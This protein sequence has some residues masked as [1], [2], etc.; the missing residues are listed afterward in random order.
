MTAMREREWL[1]WADDG[2]PAGEPPEPGLPRM[3]TEELRDF[4]VG[5]LN[6]QIFSTAHLREPEYRLLPMVFMPL[7]FMEGELPEELGLIWE[8]YRDTETGGD[9]TFPR[10][11]N[12]LP[13]FGS[14][15]FMH[16]LDWERA[17]VAIEREQRLRKELRV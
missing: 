11:I 7:A 3:T 10:A 9:N 2:G 5:V 16:R 4:V 12:G 17:R 8:W 1:R 13:V 14:C 6:C 15:R